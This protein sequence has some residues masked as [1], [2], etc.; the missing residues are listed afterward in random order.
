VPH[1]LTHRFRHYSKRPEIFNT[2]FGAT[3][4]RFLQEKKEDWWKGFTENHLIHM[5]MFREDWIILGAKEWIEQFVVDREKASWLDTRDNYTDM[6]T[7]IDDF[8]DEDMTTPL[9][10]LIKDLM[11]TTVP[12][13]KRTYHNTLL[14]AL[15]EGLKKDGRIHETSTIEIFTHDVTTFAI[16]HQH[17][18]ITQSRNTLDELIK[19]NCNVSDH[20]YVNANSYA[21]SPNSKRGE[22][23]THIIAD[24]YNVDVVIM[25][26]G[27]GINEL[28]YQTRVN[29]SNV[30]DIVYHVYQDNAGGWY[31]VEMDPFIFPSASR[32]DDDDD[33]RNG[34]GGGGGNNN[35]GDDDGEDG[36]NPPDFGGNGSHDNLFD[37][38]GDDNVQDKNTDD[39]GEYVICF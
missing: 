33:D 17:K 1:T 21:N 11:V 27:I 5:L 32:S 19:R 3:M 10:T 38:D 25:N 6:K 4:K 35:E 28:V 31:I 7:L 30:S 22:V 13:E 39:E 23:E 34:G 8:D 29:S 14:E 9:P 26:E 20:Q 18:I 16:N 15:F 37:N 36:G 12:Q 2:L 24:M